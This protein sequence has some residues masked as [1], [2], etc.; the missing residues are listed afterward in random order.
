LEKDYDICWLGMLSVNV[1]YQSHGLGRYIISKSETYAMEIFKCT[2]MKMKVISVRK[3]LIDYYLRRGYSLTG[4][5][6]LFSSSKDTFGK[7]SSSQLTFIM[8]KKPLF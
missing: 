3:E 7:P 1:N 5:S 2:V 8:L 6:E 4:E